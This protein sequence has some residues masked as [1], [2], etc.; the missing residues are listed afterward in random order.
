MESVSVV[1]TGGTVANARNAAAQPSAST[2][3]AVTDA[4]SAAAQS[5]ASTGGSRMA[6]TTAVPS[7]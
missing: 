6:V 1:S 5:S 7:D 2:G 3:G 4:R